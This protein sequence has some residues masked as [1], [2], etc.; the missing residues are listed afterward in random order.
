MAF[1]FLKGLTTPSGDPLEVGEGV[2]ASLVGC[3]EVHPAEFPLDVLTAP[4][5]P[6]C[7][8]STLDTADSGGEGVGKVL[9]DLL[10]APPDPSN[11]GLYPGD[12]GDVCG[13]S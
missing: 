8:R 12:S 6:L 5:D 9:P 10:K 13:S 3:P 7:S 11:P 1:L 2:E 4:P